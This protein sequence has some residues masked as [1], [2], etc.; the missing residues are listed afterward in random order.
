MI[1]TYQQSNSNSV[2]AK[3]S[4]ANEPKSDRFIPS[5]IEP[6]LFNLIQSGPEKTLDQD[7]LSFDDGD[8]T[9]LNHNQVENQKLHNFN[10]LLERQIIQQSS[11]KSPTNRY[12]A[13]RLFSFQ[14]DSKISLDNNELIDLDTSMNGMCHTVRNISSVPYKILDAPGLQDDFYLNILDWTKKNQVVVAL[15]NNIYT[16]CPINSK[17]NRMFTSS[18]EESIASL[19][20]DSSGNMLAVGGSNG[21]IRIFDL[22]KEK[23][24]ISWRMQHWR[25]GS[26][27]WGGDLLAS[28]SRDRSIL[29]RDL[30]EGNDKVAQYIGHKQEV[31]GQAWS[32]NHTYLA[33]GGN[34]NNVVIWDLRRG[35][36]LVKFCDHT[37]AVKALE[38]SPHNTSLLLTGGGTSDKSIKI[39]SSNTCKQVKSIDTGSQVCALKFSTHQNE[40][41]SSHGYSQNQIRV[42]QM[43]QPRKIAVLNGH[44]SRVLYMAQSPDGSHVVT[45]AGDETLRFWEV[46]PNNKSSKSKN[47]Q[48]NSNI[49]VSNDKNTAGD[50]EE[51]IR[52]KISLKKDISILDSLR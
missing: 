41:V 9:L 36:E 34:D 22:E 29:I 21:K 27:S 13:R 2:Q 1:K 46:F 6:N 7:D 23:E 17:A 10:L 12:K 38:W 51:P 50:I 14:R 3:I 11:N 35:S 18:S 42:W 26:L 52:N 20:S 24:I 28:G 43:P 49:A 44:N 8:E 4:R 45:G 5:K 19:K 25:V 33:S 16:W 32:P 39:W 37:A 40:F 30:R 48:D 15:S 31:C 47:T